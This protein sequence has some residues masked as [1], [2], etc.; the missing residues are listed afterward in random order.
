M[1]YFQ[2]VMV[3]LE[4]AADS[5]TVAF[6]L[7]Q[8]APVHVLYG[9]FRHQLKGAQFTDLPTTAFGLLSRPHAMAKLEGVAGIYAHWSPV[10]V[11]D[12]I[13]IG[14]RKELTLLHYD[15][16]ILVQMILHQLQLEEILEE[17]A[18]SL[19]HFQPSDDMVGVQKLIQFI[20]V[21]NGLRV[22]TGPVHFAYLACYELQTVP[23]RLRDVL[24]PEHM[25]SVLDVADRYVQN[26]SIT[27]QVDADIEGLRTADGDVVRHVS[28][29]FD[30]RR[31][32]EAGYF[33]QLLMLLDKKLSGEPLN[34]RPVRRAAY[35]DPRL[36]KAEVFLDGEMLWDGSRD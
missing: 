30:L 18:T 16:A 19:T 15:V 6:L 31:L 34:G 33:E 13:P 10:P 4:V 21:A 11:G 17:F 2:D 23:L 29:L 9:A 7:S 1:I 5:D 24:D 22:L 35:T 3:G 8:P 36:S 32:F 28:T 27:A 25:Q 14:M 12:P 20:D 26:L